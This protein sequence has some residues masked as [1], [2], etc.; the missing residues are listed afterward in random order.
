MFEQLSLTC[1]SSYQPD[2]LKSLQ[3]FF[4]RVSYYLAVWQLPLFGH[5]HK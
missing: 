2:F 1:S 4:G 3:S 5:F